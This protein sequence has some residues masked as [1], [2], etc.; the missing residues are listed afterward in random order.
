MPPDGR[1]LFDSIPADLPDELIETLFADGGVR[2]ER[3]VSRGHT[4]SADSWYDQDESEFVLH[5]EG[6]AELEVGG[7]DAPTR[8]EKGDWIVLPAHRRRRV[9]WT[10]PDRDTVWLAVFSRP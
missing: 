8:L 3:I 6:A 9:S 2:I 1:N 10:A 5:V 4:T 7:E